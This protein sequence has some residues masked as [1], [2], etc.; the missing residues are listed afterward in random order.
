MEILPP[1]KIKISDIKG[2]GRGVIATKDIK[3]GEIIETRSVH[4]T[5]R[6]QPPTGDAVDIETGGP[7]VGRGPVHGRPGVIGIL[8]PGD[9]EGRIV[10][11]LCGR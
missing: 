3:K 11:G 6:R 8:Q 7:A 4:G 1:E 5:H 2:K 9:V 10:V